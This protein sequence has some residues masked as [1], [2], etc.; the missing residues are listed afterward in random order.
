MQPKVTV[1]IDARKDKIRNSEI[2]ELT[3]DINNLQDQ[4]LLQL[5]YQSI[6]YYVLRLVIHD[7]KLLVT[8]ETRRIT[9]SF[10]DYLLKKKGIEFK[11]DG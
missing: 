4:N 2:K 8:Y 3:Y 7:Q 1:W 10:I 5:I 11:R 6:G 9:P